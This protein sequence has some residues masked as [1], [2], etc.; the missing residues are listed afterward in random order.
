M[1]PRKS[2]RERGRREQFVPNSDTLD[3]RKHLSV[4]LVGWQGVF[5]LGAPSSSSSGPESPANL[6]KMSNKQNVSNALQSAS[7]VHSFHWIQ[8]LG[9]Q[10]IRP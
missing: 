3:D 1:E 7:V 2:E 9:I 6:L 8:N 5:T 4:F 10:Q